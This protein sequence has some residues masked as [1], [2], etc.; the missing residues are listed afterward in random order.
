ML[1]FEHSGSSHLLFIEELGF[2]LFLSWF[3]DFWFR[4]FISRIG[5]WWLSWFEHWILQS[6][7]MVDL[8]YW[9]SFTLGIQ[10]LRFR[11]IRIHITI[12]LKCYLSPELLSFSRMILWGF[13]S[14]KIGLFLCPRM[15]LNGLSWFHIISKP[16]LFHWQNYFPFYF[17]FL[18]LRCLERIDHTG[19]WLVGKC[20]ICQI[21]IL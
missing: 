8:N 2:Y 13:L 19:H 11:I 20:L 5:S 3:C 18:L 4:R 21:S 9:T 17:V 10:W 7:I 6:S 14:D 12:S 1:F 16:L 15:K